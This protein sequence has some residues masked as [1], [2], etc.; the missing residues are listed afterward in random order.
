MS[1]GTCFGCETPA[2]DGAVTGG[3]VSV[4][5]PTAEV[6]KTT[7]WQKVWGWFKKAAKKVYDVVMPGVIAGVTAFLNDEDNQAAAVAAVKAAIDGGLRGDDAWATARGVLVDQLTKSGK[8]ASNTVIDTILQN[9]YCA[10]KYQTDK[11]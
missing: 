4:S 2:G 9:A 8:E 5:E 7:F 11:Q 3:L 6:A 10:V 1:E